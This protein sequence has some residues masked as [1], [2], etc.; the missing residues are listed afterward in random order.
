SDVPLTVAHGYQS[1]KVEAKDRKIPVEIVAQASVRSHTHQ[2]VTV[3][4]APGSTVTL[5]AVDNG[6]LQVSDFSTPDPYGHFYAK[7]ALEV[8]GYDLYPLLFPEVKASLSSTGGDG[9]S[10]MKKRVNPMPAKRIKILS[11]WSGIAE[12]NGSGEATFEFDIPQF[13]GQVRLMAVAY[14]NESFGSKESTMT[15][16]DPIVLSSALPRF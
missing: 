1:V 5:S 2:K 6:V 7:R 4:A 13:S 10:D 16:A 8:Y 12:A 3:K 9:E 11:Y 14:K 15:V